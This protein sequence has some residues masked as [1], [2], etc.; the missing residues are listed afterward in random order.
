M[1]LVAAQVLP[2]FGNTAFSKEARSLQDNDMPNNFV[3]RIMDANV[4]ISNVVDVMTQATDSLFVC[5]FSPDTGTAT[6]MKEPD[7]IRALWEELFKRRRA[8]EEDDLKPIT[9]SMKLANFHNTWMHSWLRDNLTAEQKKDKSSSQQTSI[10][11]AWLRN[12]YGSKR[13]VM[14]IAESGLSWATASGATEHSAAASSA[15]DADVPIGSPEY[16]INRFIDWILKVVKAIDQHKKDP[17]VDQQRRK[18]GDKKY[19][20]GLNE[21]ELKLREERQRARDNYMYGEDLHRRL[22]LYQGKGKA[23]G[24]GKRDHLLWSIS[25][26]SM[27]KSQQWWLTQFW[28]GNLKRWKEEAEDK[29]APR[30]GNTRRFRM[31]DYQ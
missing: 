24:K 27:N 17:T 31:A 1:L 16:S 6:K 18:S 28:N 2:A 23:T 15:G 7:E 3:A 25:W 21:R 20:H 10:F 4:A 19:A 8:F 13:F 11:G 12:N 30:T 26:D 14:A 29:Y 9:D 5:K 22:Q